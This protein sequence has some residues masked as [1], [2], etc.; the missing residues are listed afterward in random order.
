MIF[1]TLQITYKRYFKLERNFFKNKVVEIIEW[2]QSI[3]YLKKMNK[4]FFCF[5]V[6]D[7]FY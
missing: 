2:N 5:K 7:Y 3:N 4:K 1:Y 6:I